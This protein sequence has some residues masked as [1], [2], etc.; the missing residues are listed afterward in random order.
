MIGIGLRT[1]LMLQRHFFCVHYLTWPLIL[2]ITSR[3]IT[4]LVGPRMGEGVQTD[5]PGQM[6]GQIDGWRVKALKQIR[7]GN[8]PHTHS[9]S[10]TCIRTHTHTH[11]HT[12]SKQLFHHLTYII[13]HVDECPSPPIHLSLANPTIFCSIFTSLSLFLSL[14]S[15]LLV[16]SQSNF[17]FATHTHAHTQLLWGKQMVLWW[18]RCLA[19]CC[20]I[21]T[22]PPSL[23]LSVTVPSIPNF[24]LS[25]SVGSMPAILVP[26][27]VIHLADVSLF[28]HFIFYF[29][30]YPYYLSLSTSPFLCLS[31]SHSISVSPSLYI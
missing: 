16:E 5:R 29:S 15:W 22:L 6:D 31:P 27:L 26:A 12:K 24:S 2:F 1:T 23:F 13:H 10:H 11:T 7:G 14:F 20:F 17:S 19:S 25:S 8:L 18:E 21:Q 3:R 9:R 28:S 30:L 4:T